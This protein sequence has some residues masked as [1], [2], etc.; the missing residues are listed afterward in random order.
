MDIHKRFVKCRNLALQ[1]CKARLTA[2]EAVLLNLLMDI[3]K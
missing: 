3:H 2:Y 1:Y